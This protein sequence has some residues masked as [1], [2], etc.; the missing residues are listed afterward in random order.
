M[1]V[2]LAG[3]ECRFV[4]A[5]LWGAHPRAVCA[6]VPREERYWVRGFQVG[7]KRLVSRDGRG[8]CVHEGFGITETMVGLGTVMDERIVV[9]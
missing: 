6:W 7:I 9:G 8:A 1:E 3:R 4:G 5:R 2:G